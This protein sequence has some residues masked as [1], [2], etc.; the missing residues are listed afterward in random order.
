MKKLK[1]GVPTSLARNS[2]AAESEGG[3]KLVPCRDTGFLPPQPPAR[4]AT[5]S[6][7][8]RPS[9]LPARAIGFQNSQSG[10]CSKKV[11]ILTKRHRI[12]ILYFIF[13]F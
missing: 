13:N 8:G 1:S 4:L 10:F 9:F 6:V 11:R 5:R 2:A 7:A 3:Q 12:Y